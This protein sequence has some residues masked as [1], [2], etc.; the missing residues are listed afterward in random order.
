MQALL[1]IALTNCF[2]HEPS[3]GSVLSK[4]WYG[5][6]SMVGGDRAGGLP[7]CRRWK[8]CFVVLM[9]L[10]VPSVLVGSAGAASTQVTEFRLP[11]SPSSAWGIAAAPDGSMWLGTTR[12]QPGLRAAEQNFIPEMSR[13][14]PSGD[15]TPVA[16]LPQAALGMRASSNGNVW[17]FGSGDTIG[18]VTPSGQVAE[19]RVPTRGASSPQ[20][21]TLGPE[22]NAWFTEYYGHVGRVDTSGQ[23]TEFSLPNEGS[24]PGDITTGPDGNLWFTEQLEGVPDSARI[25]RI[26]PSGQATAFVLP[27]GSARPVGIA[28]GQDGS[29]WFTEQSNPPA[30]GRI[31]PAGEVTKFP[32]PTKAGYPG[33]MVQGSDGR[34]WFDYGLGAI[35]KVTPNGRITRIQLPHKTEVNAITLG[36]EGNIWYTAQSEP[37]C[38]GGGGTCIAQIL[39]EPGIVGRVT[40]GPLA[41]EVRVRRAR[42]PGRWAKLRLAC[43]GGDAED[44]C[45]GRIRLSRR[46]QSGTANRRQRMAKR[47][48]T[49]AAG[50]YTLAADEERRI[51]V[52]LRRRALGLL[53]R[54]GRLRVTVTVAVRKGQNASRSVVLRSRARP[55]HQRRR[56]SGEG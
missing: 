9:V 7:M 36:P 8:P 16:A 53:S 55:R 23:I 34:L 28:A 24:H 18:R 30:V 31:T 20:A 45:R 6:G 1:P 10:L 22:G 50:R 48:V 11:S 46:L 21:I 33:Q 38:L 37:P 14:L 54:H 32:F 42:V 2:G 39:H 13:L 40:P 43:V 12:G 4:V 47:N 25:G 5:P 52:R 26:T 56:R 27:A 15:I 41:V 35:G 44:S 49:L 3:S 19:F 29:I 51:A 17:Y